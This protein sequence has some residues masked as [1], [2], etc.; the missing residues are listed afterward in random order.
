MVTC[1][2]YTAQANTIHIYIGMIKNRACWMCLQTKFEIQHI[3]KIQ[4]TLIVISLTKYFTVRINTSNEN[5]NISS[6]I[7]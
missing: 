1:S 5:L 2:L 4:M 6:N 7:T 3:I